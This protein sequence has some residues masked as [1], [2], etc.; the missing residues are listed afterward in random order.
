MLNKKKAAF[1]LVCLFVVALSGCSDAEMKKFVWTLRIMVFGAGS[2]CGAV[3]GLIWCVIP[4]NSAAE[5]SKSL[6]TAILMGGI[7]GGFF[8][9][10][11][12]LVFWYGWVALEVPV[13]EILNDL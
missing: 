13:F 9:L 4:N 6:P 5:K 1:L 3:V 12:W 2:F 10:V 7:I 11:V 8:F